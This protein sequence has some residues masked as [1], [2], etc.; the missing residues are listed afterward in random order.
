MISTD[1]T[2]YSTDSPFVIAGGWPETLGRIRTRLNRFTEEEKKRLVNWGY[3]QADLAIRSYYRPE[4]EA[5]DGLPFPE[6]S[7]AVEP[8][9]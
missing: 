9:V 1:P 6:Y 7:F 3:I 8:R 4:L 2:R 5:P